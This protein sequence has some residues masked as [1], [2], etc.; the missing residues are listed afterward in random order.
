MGTILKI[1]LV[2]VLLTIILTASISFWLSFYKWINSYKNAGVKM[3]FGQFRRIYELAP[4][5]WK[6]GFDYIYRRT[7][8]VRLDSD[9]GNFFGTYISTAVAM[10]TLF[11]FW[12]LLFWQDEI[13]RKKER[14][15]R[16]KEEKASL[17]NLT[18]M[19]ENDAETIRKKLEEEEQEAE[20]LRQEIID[21]LGGNK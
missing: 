9:R 20:R 3:S 14:E 11:D 4:S 5:E 17:K 2:F 1:T 15:K 19:I 10:K 21:R 18:I 6:Q 12:R 8:R 16:L 13:D 7:E